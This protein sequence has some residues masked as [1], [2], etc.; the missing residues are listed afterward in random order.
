MS[1]YFNQRD[2][3][4]ALLSSSLSEFLIAIIHFLPSL[5]IVPLNKQ[6]QTWRLA[7]YYLSVFT[8]LWTVKLY[9]D[10]H[11][12]SFCLFF[13]YL[14]T[15]YW[16]TLPF[17]VFFFLFL[18]SLFHFSFYLYIPLYLFLFPF[19]LLPFFSY[20]CFSSSNYYYIMFSRLLQPNL[21]SS[22]LTVLFVLTIIFSSLSCFLFLFQPI[23][24]F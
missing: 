17:Y 12:F 20:F 11:N 5:T 18:L 19:H 21:F 22:L 3:G 6:F 16:T 10:I 13:F 4:T 23:P 24:Q 14:P 2:L 15:S 9:N 8:H 7:G 1:V